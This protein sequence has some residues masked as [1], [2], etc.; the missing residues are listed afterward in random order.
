MRQLMLSNQINSTTS[1]EGV[2]GIR[3]GFFH[4]FESKEVI[5]NLINVNMFIK[6]K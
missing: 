6:L 3:T 4:F 1:K 2:Q 5:C